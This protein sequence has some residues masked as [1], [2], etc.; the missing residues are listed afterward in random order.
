MDW[1][2][3]AIRDGIIVVLV[4]SGPLVLAAAFIGLIIGI[5]QAATQVQEQTIGSALKIIGVFALIIFAGFWMYQY[6]NQYTSKVLSSAF[7]LVPN[8][9]QKVIPPHA[10]E[11]DEKFNVTF[12]EEDLGGGE[13]LKVI[14]PERLEEK[15]LPQNG[16]P[17]GAPYLGAPEIPKAPVVTKQL[18]VPPVENI[19]K[20]PVKLDMQFPEFQKQEPISI[21]EIPELPKPP[22]LKIPEQQ[23]NVPADGTNNNQPPQVENPVQD[24]LMAQPVIENETESSGINEQQLN[25]STGTENTNKEEMIIPENTD[26]AANPSWLN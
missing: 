25:N 12:D 13:P 4:I 15:K 8:R 20:P 2:P 5:L 11:N 24:N 6:L 14:P 3:Q 7:R 22:E 18:P 23:L 10:F 1:M 16:I 21:P 17:V 26:D 9:T 19:P